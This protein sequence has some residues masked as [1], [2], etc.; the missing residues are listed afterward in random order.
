LPPYGRFA[1]KEYVEGQTVPVLIGQ[2]LPNRMGA[3]AGSASALPSK[4]KMMIIKKPLVDPNPFFSCAQ[5]FPHSIMMIMMFRIGKNTKSK[6]NQVCRSIGTPDGSS[7]GVI[8]QEGGIAGRE[9]IRT[10]NPDF[11]LPP[12]ERSGL[13][14]KNPPINY[15]RGFCPR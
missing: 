10:L 5:V 2:S 13:F 15:G 6:K 4:K 8:Q 11:S 14:P 12:A 1:K 3:W 9:L 7:S